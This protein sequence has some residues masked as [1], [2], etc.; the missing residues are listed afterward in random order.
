LECQQRAPDYQS[1]PDCR[2]TSRE[3]LLELVLIGGSVPPLG[4]Q[5]RRT[6]GIYDRVDV[7]SKPSGKKDASEKTYVPQLK[8]A[9]DRQEVHDSFHV[10]AIVDRSEPRQKHSE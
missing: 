4:Y 5:L 7:E 10:L 6:V 8:K 1:K 9:R 2:R 3:S